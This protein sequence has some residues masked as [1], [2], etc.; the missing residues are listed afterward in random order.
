M[1]SL[2]E[3]L[4]TISRL[5]AME[6]LSK[7]Q[8]DISELAESIVHD[9]QKFYQEKSITTTTHIKKGVSK[10]AHKNSLHI[11]IKNILENAYKFTPE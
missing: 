5:E 9:L 2:L 3:T 1:N 7:Q 8:T 10:K 4:V 11:I 6:T